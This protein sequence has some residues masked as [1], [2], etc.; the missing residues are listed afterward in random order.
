MKK[1]Y[2][3]IIIILTICTTSFAETKEELVAK[4]VLE[5]MQQDYISCY[6]FY[7]IGAEVVKKSN[8]NGDIAKGIE[9]SADASLKL[10]FET[11]ELMNMNVEFM[12]TKIQLEMKKQSDEIDNDYNNASILLKKYGG[13]CKNLI[14]NKKKRIDHWEKLGKN[15]FK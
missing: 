12:K 11:G 15:I 9:K 14:E 1:I 10:A 6:I 13:L 4:Y 5:N 2:L 3:Q 7:K 8:K